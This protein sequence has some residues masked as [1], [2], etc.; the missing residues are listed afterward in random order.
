MSTSN[1]VAFVGDQDAKITELPRRDAGELMFQVLSKGDL[2][3]LSAEE[4]ARYEVAVC[5]S[6]GLNPLTKPFD[7]ITLPGSKKKGAETSDRKVLYANRNAGDQL[8]GI[9]KITREIVGREVVDGVY[10]VTARASTPDGRYDE[11]IGAV[12]LL[13][14]GGRWVPRDDGQGSVFQ[15]DGTFTPLPPDQRANKMMHAETKAKRRAV[16]SLVGLSFLDESEL[17]TMG[18]RLSPS[19]RM[20]DRET[21]EIVSPSAPTLAIPAESAER[22]PVDSAALDPK[23]VATWLGNID[24]AKNRNRLDAIAE[25]LANLGMDGIEELASALTI[26]YA[27]FDEA[28]A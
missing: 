24:R 25:S 7:V 10:I 6:V 20:V 26:R 1:A 4:I 11:S 3:N 18:D 17:D 28:P 8:C 23:I 9:H 2:S 14:E 22:E 15:P 13:K 21:G 16:L 5:E 12:P 19:V 27:E